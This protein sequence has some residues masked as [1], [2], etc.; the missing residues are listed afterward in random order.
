MCIQILQAV[1]AAVGHPTVIFHYYRIVNENVTQ[2]NFQ[3]QCSDLQTLV[4]I[5]KYCWYGSNIRQYLNIMTYTV[6]MT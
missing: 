3:V 5:L 6:I 4:R 2:E 1:S